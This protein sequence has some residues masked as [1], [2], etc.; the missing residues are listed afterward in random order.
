MLTK[1]R[2]QNV[3]RQFAIEF[4]YPTYTGAVHPRC[5]TRERYTNGCG[6]VH[7]ARVIATEQREAR[8]VL[9][10]QRQN[11]NA[12]VEMELDKSA[13]VELD[14]AQAR[15]DASIDELM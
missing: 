4:G 3:E 5:G 8:K 7:C 9:K 2:P 15:H 6:C 11:F 12:V 1:G 13:P 14:D 10:Q